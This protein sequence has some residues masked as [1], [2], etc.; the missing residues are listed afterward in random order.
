MYFTFFKLYKWYQTARSITI[1]QH[2]SHF[3]RCSSNSQIFSL[4]STGRILSYLIS[5]YVDQ[6][7]SY[8]EMYSKPCQTSKLKHFAKIVRESSILDVWLSCKYASVKHVNTTQ[9]AEKN[10]YLSL[11]EL[12]KTTHNNVKCK[13]HKI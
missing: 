2:R 5:T 10:C 11:K 12:T 13:C 6:N 9:I 8:A 4:R 1:C 7:R 3:F